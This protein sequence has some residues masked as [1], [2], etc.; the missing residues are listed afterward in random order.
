MLIETTVGDIVVDL[1]YKNF[2]IES[3]NFIKLCK[4]N[5]YQYQCFYELEKNRSVQFGDPLAGF[6]D[7]KDLKVHNTSI[8]GVLRHSE[9]GQVCARLIKPTC[10][11]T[12]CYA[13]K[14]QLGAV[15]SHQKK[16]SSKL[17]GSQVLISLSDT[18]EVFEDTIFFGRVIENSLST[19]KIVNATSLDHAGRATVDIRIRKMYVIFDPFPNIPDFPILQ[20]SQPFEDVRLPEKLLIKYH[21]DA[22]KQK[23]QLDIRRKELSL[24]IIGDLPG[25]GI[26][27][28]A[29][30][31]FIC[32]L[33]PL[34]KAK[35]IATI[36]QR[37]GEIISVEIVRSKETGFSL[38]YGFIEFTTRQACESAYKSMDGTLIDDKRI[39]VD[40]SQS[41]RISYDRRKK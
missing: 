18:V 22:D 4:S 15:V 25:V 19:L 28:S 6:N 1:D 2:E 36:F 8:E 12:L 17:I 29:N 35:D 41:C 5:F 23:V 37:F 7:R 24:E 13:N 3:Y 27:P 14:G 30:V 20:V 21:E 10:L 26:K 38:C 40:F 31:L 11:P 39:H 34:T 32:K 16:S 33:N 9:D